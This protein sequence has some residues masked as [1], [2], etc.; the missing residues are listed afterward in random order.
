MYWL[1]VHVDRWR[2]DAAQRAA[3]RHNSDWINDQL[4]AVAELHPN[5][6]VV[7]WAAVVTD[8]WLA[9]GVHPSPAG[10]TAWCELLETA[11]FDGVSGR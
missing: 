7:D 6:V 10:I 4:R 5:L 9:D 3:D 8:D 11:L 1:T 2:G